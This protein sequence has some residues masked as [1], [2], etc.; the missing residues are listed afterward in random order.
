MSDILLVAWAV[1]D[2]L[3]M[4]DLTEQA[5]AILSIAAIPQSLSLLQYASLS[6]PTGELV[7]MIKGIN[8]IN[9]NFDKNIHYN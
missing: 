2:L 8:I 3:N 4:E 7:I 9:N 6:K 1:I 5:H